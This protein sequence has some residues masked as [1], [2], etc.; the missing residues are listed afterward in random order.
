MPARHRQVA[1]VSKPGP[2]TGANHVTDA[3][4]ETALR[5]LRTQIAYPPTPDVSRAVGQR[6]AARTPITAP[7]RRRF[8]PIRAAL[9]LAAALL[10]ALGA[11]LAAS[12]AARSTLAHWFHIPGVVVNTVPSLPPAP[13]SKLDLGERSTLSAAQNRA[14]FTI[15]QPH[16]TQLGA[17]DAVYVRAAPGGVEVSFFYRPRPDFPQASQT[18]A[19]LLVS[20]FRGNVSPFMGKL[21]G[22]GADVREVTVNGQAGY[23]VKGGHEFFYQGPDGEFEQ[24]TLR[25]S[26]NAVLWSE[27]GVTFRIEGNI[28]EAQAMTVAE[29][30]K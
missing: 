8:A 30:M 4:L 24:D 25:L 2:P 14:G 12:P 23:W 1:S 28:S 3:E 5:N 22:S 17:P 15:K 29:S 20:E 21:V 13:G 9:V 10:L 7:Q 6:L 27:S 16:L 26:A 19:G 11:A 18:G